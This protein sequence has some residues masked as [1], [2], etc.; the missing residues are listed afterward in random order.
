MK[1][2]RLLELLAA[3]FPAGK[4][5]GAL[6]SDVTP[7]AKINTVRGPVSVEDL[8]V[9]LMH[10]HVMVDFVGA[11]GV[12]RDRYHVD[13]VFKTVL[14]YLTRVHELG[15]RTLVE[16]TPA[17]LGRDPVLL[18]RLS[19]ASGLHLLTNTGY[20]GAAGGK[21]V[22]QHAAREGAEALSRRWIDEYRNGI[23]ETGV[24]PAFT[25]IGVNKG[26]LSPLDAKLVRAAARTHLSTGLT[27]ASHTGDGVAA[28]R[29]LDV[30]KGEGVA[31]SAFIWVH[32]QNEPDL[33]VHLRAAER[34]AW[35]EF[36][37]ISDS[38][39]EKRVAQV[40]NLIDH[41]FLHQALISLDAGWYNVGEPGGGVFHTYDELLTRFVPALKGAGVSESQIRALLVENPRRALNPIVRRA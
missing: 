21:Y 25:K 24:K 31:G 1:R 9:V 5:S 19:E 38:S 40:K 11:D 37:G 28:A 10:E 7:S 15:C 35:I 13:E 39:V 6:S 34:G 18:R 4:A 2:R 20:Y 22:P 17:F 16:C 30:L 27:I 36:E 29:Q 26:P 12:S 32:A 14:P 3:C 33:N 41:D 8:G 23:E